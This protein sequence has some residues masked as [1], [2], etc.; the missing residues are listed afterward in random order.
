MV[1]GGYDGEA[2]CPPYCRDNA[3]PYFYYGSYTYFSYSEEKALYGQM[4]LNLDKFKFTAG[5]RDY[6]I[7][8]GYKSSEFGIFY[9]G[10][11]TGCDGTSTEGTTCNQES[12]SE[13]DTRPKLTATYMPNDDLTFFVVQ[14]AGYRPGGNNS[15][16]P[17][18][19]AGDPEAANFQRRFTSDKSENF[20]YGVKAR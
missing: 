6:E 15:A 20:E 18:F 16:L 17:P 4:A 7:S 19:C 12:G 1:P 11:N 5:L 13:A 9:Y 10:G 2:Y 3:S 14:S 8:D